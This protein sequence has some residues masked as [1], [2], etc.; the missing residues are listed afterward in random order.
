MR[1]SVPHCSP[2]LSHLGYSVLP[3]QA[4]R[5]SLNSV[6]FMHFLRVL[7]HSAKH[8]TSSIKAAFSH[9]QYPWSNSI[10]RSSSV[11][12]FLFYLPAFQ[13]FKEAL[14]RLTHGSFTPNIIPHQLPGLRDH[15]GQRQQYKGRS[16][17]PVLFRWS[18]V[19][20]GKPR[21]P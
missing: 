17:Q 13:W 18:L 21:H 5:Y 2:G 3:L 10:S 16:E 6:C 1:E 11:E 7:F 4:E 19:R 9:R 15:T 8:F 14:C 20:G 12:Q